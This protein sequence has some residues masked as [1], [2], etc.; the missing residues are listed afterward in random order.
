MR[1]APMLLAVT[2][3]VG[4]AALRAQQRAIS[5][6]DLY[7]FRWIASPQISPDGRQV[8]YVLVTVNAKHDGYETSLWIVGTDGEGWVDPTEHSHIWTVSAAVPGSGEQPAEA[9]QVTTGTFD[10]NAPQW[11]PDGARIYFASDRVVESYYYPPD[12]NFYSVPAAG[13]A[14]D[15]AANIDGPICGPVLSPD[16]TAVA[17]R[18]WINPRAARSYNQSDLFVSRGRTAKNLTADYDF[19][20]GGRDRK[21]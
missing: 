12:N 20:M 2:S 16:G 10:E 13:G 6:S 14:L 19:D 15:T 1:P 3:F 7:A 8:A 5:D 21:S 18:G 4:V 9:H 17:F 11:S